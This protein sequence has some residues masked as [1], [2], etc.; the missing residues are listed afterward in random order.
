M[1]VEGSRWTRT[2]VWS[3]SQLDALE[4]FSLMK[5]PS[6]I[7]PSLGC[8]RL[9][10]ARK[11]KF[12]SRENLGSGQ[13]PPNAHIFKWFNSGALYWHFPKSI[14]PPSYG[15]PNQLLAEIGGKLTEIWLT[16][17]YTQCDQTKLDE[18]CRCLSL[19]RVVN[20][21]PILNKWPFRDLIHGALVLA[22]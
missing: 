12:S 21:T 7:Q 10:Y 15:P 1:V 17:F 4:W 18:F 9:R 2:P 6:A 13:P 16:P 8:S 5:G 3:K 22:L 19:L 14:L 20:R 11:G